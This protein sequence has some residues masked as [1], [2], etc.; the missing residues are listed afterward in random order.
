[1]SIRD[2]RFDVVRQIIAT[3]PER[4]D[5]YAVLRHPLFQEGHDAASSLGS[6][7]GRFLS[8]HSAELGIELVDK[9]RSPAVWRK[10]QLVTVEDDSSAPA[11]TPA[12]R[13][14]GPQ[15]SKDNPF[16][17]RM[18]RHQSWW[19]DEVLQAPYGRG[20]TPTSAAYYGNMLDDDGSARLLNFLNDDIRR[21]YLEREGSGV[22]PFRARR[23][24]LSSQPMCFNLFGQLAA[25]LDLATRVMLRVLPDVERVTDVRLEWAPHPAQEHLADRTSF[26]AA[27]DYLTPSGE[28]AFLGVETKLTEPFSPTVYDTPRYR[29]LTERAGSPW[30]S[31]SWPHL[32]D[33]RWNQLWRNHLLVEAYR[34]HPASGVT[35]PARLA[36]VR[37]HQDLDC[38]RAVAGYRELVR[39]E[40]VIDLPLDVLHDAVTAVVADETER[41]WWSDFRRRYIDLS[42]SA[43]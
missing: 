36:I 18:R 8:R 34:H 16:T 38:A 29:Q 20:P 9:S 23:N 43:S 5:T 12:R 14:I 40:S 3:L 17:A 6:V 19:R 10:L 26:D 42:G 27:I 30:P 15:Y 7:T 41:R 21:V 1:M 32:A 4:F 39:R 33:A 37:H 35:G 25:N 22:E 24:L 31:Q 13:G 11:A 28:R 2:V